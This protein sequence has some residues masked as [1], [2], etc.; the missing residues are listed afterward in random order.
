MYTFTDL[1]ITDTFSTTSTII[2]TT[3]ETQTSTTTITTV[4]S[5]PDTTVT[6]TYTVPTSSGFLPIAD[7]T[8]SAYPAKLKREVS[9]PHGYGLSERE[10]PKKGICGAKTYPVAVQ[11]VKVIEKQAVN[12]VVRTGKP[13][14]KI[15]PRSTISST[16][17]ITSTTTST[18]VPP[19][20]STTL[21]FSATSTVTEQTTST[22]TSTSTSVAQNTVSMTVSSYAACA[23]NN[24][25]GPTL[26]NGET[27]YLYQ[28][29]TYSVTPGTSTT[30]CCEKCQSGTSC[31]GVG[32]NP[33][34]GYCYIFQASGGVLCTISWLQLAIFGEFYKAFVSPLCGFLCG[35]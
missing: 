27:I 30:D 15:L 8:A 29:A 20:V 35:L 16:V 32:Y 10:Q 6:A 33:K 26:S 34:N 13:I 24:I 1:A 3:T 22:V 14:T 7:T 17:Y 4:S 11:C 18:L 31:S 23:T 2:T 5:A 9:H 12:T 21:L 19:D 25:L 28:A